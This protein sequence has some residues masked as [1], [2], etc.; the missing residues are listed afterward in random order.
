MKYIDVDVYGLCAIDG[1]QKERINF[2]S[3]CE[4]GILVS[5]VQGSKTSKNH[6]IKC[7]PA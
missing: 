5:H 7:L 4:Y 1:K 3:L 2:D 6:I